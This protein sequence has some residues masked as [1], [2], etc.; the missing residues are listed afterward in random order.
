MKYRDFV[1][2]LADDLRGVFEKKEEMS[3]LKLWK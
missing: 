2:N 3:K 1:E